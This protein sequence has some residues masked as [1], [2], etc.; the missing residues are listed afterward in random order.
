[1]QKCAI[2]LFCSERGRKIFR[3]PFR[4]LGAV[5][6]GQVIRF[7]ADGVTARQNTTPQMYSVVAAEN[8]IGP[9]WP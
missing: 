9:A 2:N 3:Q 8:T 6:I 1:M 4:Q 5:L 7:V